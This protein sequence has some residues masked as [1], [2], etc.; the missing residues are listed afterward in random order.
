[1]ACIEIYGGPQV[2]EVR[3]TFRGRQVA[4]R[5]SREDGCQIERWDRVRF[6]FPS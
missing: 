2:A 4:A 6:L 1:M 3:G 5:F